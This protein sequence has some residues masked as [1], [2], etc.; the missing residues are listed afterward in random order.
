ML[1]LRHLRLILAHVEAMAYQEIKS[2]LAIA[3]M[4]GK[5]P[6]LTTSRVNKENIDMNMIPE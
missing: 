3:K 6:V 1:S 2:E 4:T 5:T